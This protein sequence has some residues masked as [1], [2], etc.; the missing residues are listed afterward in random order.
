MS[1]VR[2]G[3]LLQGDSIAAVP[4]GP[5]TAVPPVRT[6]RPR[7]LTLGSELLHSRG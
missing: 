5:V 6:A 4:G 2:A 7:S 1:G 3:L